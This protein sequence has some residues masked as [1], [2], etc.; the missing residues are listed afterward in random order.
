MNPLFLKGANFFESIEQPRQEHLHLA[1]VT[2]L[3]RGAPLYLETLG[4]MAKVDV[5]FPK[6]KSVSQETLE[7][8]GDRFQILIKNRNQLSSPDV[9]AAILNDYVQD[10]ELILID[11]GG[12]FVEALPG[13]MER[14]RVPL[15]GIVEVTENGHQRYAALKSLPVPVISIARS[16]LKGPE[17]Y[18]T[19]QS[20][21]Y[22]SEALM[23][24]CHHIPN[25][26][27]AVVFGYGKIGSSIAK[28]LHSKNINTK[29]VEID[30]IRAIDAR[31][32]GFDLLTKEE[33][34]QTSDIIYCATGNRSLCSSDFSLVK[35]GAFIFSV[36]SF[37]DEMELPR[38]NGS[39]QI[40]PVTEHIQ[41]Y[42]RLGQ[43]YYLANRGNAIN[44]IHNAEVGPYIFLVQGE[45]IEAM[46]YM[47]RNSLEP[48]LHELPTELR[49]S[50]AQ[51]WLNHFV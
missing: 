44:F 17:D 4:R 51:S 1:V 30:P 25:G 48:G 19:G 2:H 42:E 26:G 35:N 6:P 18:L 9:V 28:A 34:L 11:V 47:S 8:L 46:N 24:Q 3:L 43:Y 37:D 29:V 23:R 40:H 12:Y 41:R 13:L 15:R 49:R 16:P 7:Q 20:I 10:G 14:L 21:V 33:A 50:L 45:C 27:H 36:T 5:V 22:S 39:F 31:S 32:R 38:A